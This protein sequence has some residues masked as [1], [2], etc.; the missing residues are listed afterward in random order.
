MPTK[1]PL[2]GWVASLKTS[3]AVAQDLIDPVASVS[4]FGEDDRSIVSRCELQP[5][6]EL[7]SLQPGA[8]LNGSYWLEH[9]D[10]ED[11]TKLQEQIHSL[12]LSGTV[13]TTL[14]LLAELARGEKSEFYGYI[15]Q[16]PTTIS[17]PFS[18]DA[19]IREML[20]HTTAHPLLDDKLVLKMY[21]DYAVPLTKEFSTV[22]PAEV[23]T[24][25]KFQW[26]Y[27]MVSSRYGLQKILL[28]RYGFVLPVSVPSDSIHITSSEL[29]NA[30]R[31]CSLNSDNEE[32]EDYADDAPPTG[33]GKGKGKVKAKTS[34]A[35]RQKLV[36][37]EEDG[38]SLFFLL[39]G[40]AEREF[41]LSE[42]LLSF[43]MASQLPAEQLYD[44]LAVILQE[45][46]KQY[47]DLL[48]AS[49]EDTW[50]EMR[51]IRLLSQHERQ[52]CRRILL[53]LMSLEEGSDSSDDEE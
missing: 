22:W 16:L 48:S 24:V 49:S 4:A 11:K 5:G 2:L 43:V 37:P 45:K 23:S 53:G 39:H 33:N 21:S 18:W 30:F 34:P 6:A 28:C 3:V 47:S 26:A 32:Y 40:D 27:S 8:F 41:G 17:L 29:T 15:Q 51:A 35:K 36:H 19:K 10:A 12:Q 13:K 31:V 14:V 20:R 9:Y 50:P 7:V 42:A 38:S 25:E 52:V 46:D 1:S 44:A